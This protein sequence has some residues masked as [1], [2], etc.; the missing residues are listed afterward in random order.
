[1]TKRPKRR[2]KPKGDCL[3]QCVARVIGRKPHRVPDFVNKYKGR[4][5]YHFS[6]W[7]ERVGYIVIYHT[8]KR[9]STCESSEGVRAWI[10]IGTGRNGGS[11]AVVMSAL[12]NKPATVTYDGGNPLRKIE[13]IIFILPKARK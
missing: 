4:W 1:M 11:H 7:C 13:R 5:L 9:G 2:R 8:R 6:R 3:R 10:Q 12:P